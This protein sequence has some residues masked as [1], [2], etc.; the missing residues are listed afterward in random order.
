MIDRK[1]GGAADIMRYA[2]MALYRAKNEGRNR[3]CIYDAA[4]DEDLSNRKLLEADLREAIENDQLRLLY[5]PIVNKSGETVV[6]VEALCRWTHPTRG[7]IPPTEFIAVAEHSGLIIDLGD[8]VLRRACLDGKAWPG[9]TVSVNVSPLQFRRT[10]FVDV[11]RT[12]VGGNRVR[13]GRLELELTESVLLGNVD[14]AE[15]GMLRLKA[16]GVRLALD[17]F[18]TGYSSLL[19]LRRLPFDKLKIDRSF[20]LR[21]EKAADA[22]AIVHAVVEPRPRPRHEGDGRRRGDRRPAAVPARRRRAF[23]AGLSFR[24]GRDR[25]RDHRPAAIA[26]RL[27]AD[28][29]AASA[30]GLTLPA[31]SMDCTGTHP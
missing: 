27:P 25:R 22:A 15:A 9:L 28:R 3:A 12:H 16:I 20:V 13:S 10:D 29:R 26:R 17:D 11:V 2:D 23:H 7:E 24:Q 5:Q 8:W 21:I 19:Y 1:S 18:G 31:L 14:T 6:G 4:M 30:G